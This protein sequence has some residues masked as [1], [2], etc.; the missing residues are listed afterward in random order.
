MSSSNISQSKKTMKWLPSL[1]SML[2]TVVVMLLV[3]S[4]LMVVSASIP[5]AQEKGLNEFYFFY[6]QLGYMVVGVVFGYILYCIPLRYTFRLEYILLAM[7]LCIGAIILTLLGDEINGS[8][9][10]IELGGINIQPTEV[11]K[12]LVVLFTADFV[13]RRMKEFKDKWDGFFRIIIIM[14]SIIILLAFQPD[15]GSMVMIGATVTMMIFVAGL[16][17]RQVALLLGMMIMSAIMGVFAAAYRL[18]RVRSFFDPFDDILGSD[19]QLSRSL[20]AFSRG[21]ITGVGYGEGIVKLSYL[22]EAHTD[23]LLAVTGEELGMIGVSFLILL[24]II[25]ISIIMRISYIMLKRE[26]GRLSYFA[27]GVGVV[28]FGQVFINAGMTI[29]LLPTK[30]LTMPFFSYGGSSMVCCLMVI[31]ILLRIL[32]ESP[33]IAPEDCRY[34]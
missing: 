31:G 33:K 3:F 30:G 28:F 6:R 8:K 24:Q 18:E 9:R 5:F 19:M 10:W 4:L 23:F 2:I 34:Y 26:Q 14:M 21:E 20:I 13:V 22:P 15:Y 7:V 29:G 12:F 17:S 25:L 32:K 1:T 27:F 11:V 16:Q